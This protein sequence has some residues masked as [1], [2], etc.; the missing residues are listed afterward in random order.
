MPGPADGERG[1]VNGGVLVGRQPVGEPKAGSRA[2]TTC[3]ASVAL[4]PDSV[5]VSWVRGVVNGTPRILDVIGR[6]VTAVAVTPF[7][8]RSV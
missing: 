8:S 6:G 1:R 7:A 2:R 4:P 3:C 5:T